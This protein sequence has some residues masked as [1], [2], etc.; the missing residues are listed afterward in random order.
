MHTH[1]PVR[2]SLQ[3]EVVRCGLDR[4]PNASAVMPKRTYFATLYDNFEE[5][6]KYYKV[7]EDSKEKQE[8]L[9]KLSKQ[10]RRLCP[11]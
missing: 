4:N 2:R 8:A 3:T 7:I 9:A 5:D 1:R 6:K 10:D 11:A